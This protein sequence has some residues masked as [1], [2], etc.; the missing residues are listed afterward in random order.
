MNDKCPF[1]VGEKVIYNPS[2]RGHAYDDGERLKIGGQYKVKE[3]VQ[4]SYVVVE[5]YEDHP[6]GGIY[7]TEF[8]H[9]ND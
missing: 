3:I 8:E 2:S 1:K 7:W 9:L 4:E 5:G 6:G